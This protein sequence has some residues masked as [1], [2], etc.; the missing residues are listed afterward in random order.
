MLA[1]PEVGFIVPTNAINSSGQNAVVMA[2]AA[3]V[4]AINKEA[5]SSRRR[6]E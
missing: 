6:T 4:A 1:S 5:A 3:P 2:K